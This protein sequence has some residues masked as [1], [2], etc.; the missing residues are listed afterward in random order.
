[1]EGRH[2]LHGERRHYGLIPTTMPCFYPASLLSPLRACHLVGKRSSSH[3]I[4]YSNQPYHN[5]PTLSP[6]QPYLEHRDSLCSCETY[7]VRNFFYQHLH[8][9][10]TRPEPAPPTPPPH[11]PLPF[12]V[13]P[14]LSPSPSLLCSY[15][16][17]GRVSRGLDEVLHPLARTPTSSR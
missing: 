6:S 3:A 15:L 14:T 9:W 1:V 4:S 17:Q 5:P 12:C 11:P 7:G 2:C 16:H 13:P 10:T 8:F